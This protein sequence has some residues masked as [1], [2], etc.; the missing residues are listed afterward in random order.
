MKKLVLLSAVILSAASAQA[1][2]IG[3]QAIYSG[4]MAYGSNSYPSTLTL[5][6]TGP[7]AKEGTYVVKTT[8]TVA[9]QSQSST[10]ERTP[11]E[12]GDES[13]AAEFVAKCAD[14]KGTLEPITIQ[15]GE[16]L[17]TCKVSGMQNGSVV[18]IHYA[19][20]PFLT[21]RMV[22]GKTGQVSTLTLQSYRRGN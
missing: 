3:D 17:Q 20:V 14:N 10:S 18:T 2:K 4:T 21:A 13:Q 9:S 12:I 6:V 11:A 19:A 7:G 15:S 16:T 8:V 1:A 22:T 5:E